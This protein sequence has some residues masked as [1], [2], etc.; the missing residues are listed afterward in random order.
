MRIIIGTSQVFGGF[1]EIIIGKASSKVPD[2]LTHLVNS[3]APPQPRSGI[4]SLCTVDMWGWIVLCRGGCPVHCRMF[5]RIPGL[6]PLDSRSPLF[7][8][9][10]NCVLKHR[11]VPP[12]GQIRPQ[13]GSP[14][15]GS[16]AHVVVQKARGPHTQ[17]TSV[18]WL[19]CQTVGSRWA[20]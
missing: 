18:Y 3:R 13:L 5:S 11:Q 14:V 8:E 19:S 1:Y 6:C 15:A 20:Y 12:G 10:D 4:L 17:G 2:T 7:P 9:Q 16:W